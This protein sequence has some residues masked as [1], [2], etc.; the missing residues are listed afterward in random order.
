MFD[1]MFLTTVAGGRRRKFC[2]TFTETIQL[3]AAASIS[4]E[5]KI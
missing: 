4:V 2:N 3:H 1:Q 5:I